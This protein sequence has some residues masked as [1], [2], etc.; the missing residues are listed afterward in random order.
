MEYSTRERFVKEIFGHTH[1]V[2][3]WGA[4]LLYTVE[5]PEIFTIPEVAQVLKDDR[6]IA[7]PVVY[8]EFRSLRELGMVERASEELTQNAYVDQN[9]FVRTDSPLWRVAEVAVEVV[10][11]IF[12]PESNEQ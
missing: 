3:V 9:W 12:P 4:M 6:S 1:K 5:P 8:A 2:D 11:I 10:G 7:Q